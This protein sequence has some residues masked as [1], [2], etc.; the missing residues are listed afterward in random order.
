MNVALYIGRRLSFKP[1]DKR[2]KVPGVTIG[3]TGIALSLIVMMLS[4]SIVTGFKHEIRAKVMGFD[5][6]LNV[7]VQEGYNEGELNTIHLTDS[8]MKIVRGVVGER[9]RVTPMVRQPGILK[10]DSAFQGIVI[11]GVAPDYDWSFI[12]NAI[13]E[14]AVPHYAPGADSLDNTIIIS[15]LTARQLGVKAGDKLNAHF[16]RDNAIA[17]RRL[18]VAA[19][20]DT[21]FSDYDRMYAFTPLRMLQKLNH[22]DSLECG[23]LEINGVRPDRI[24]DYSDRLRVD[25]M[26]FAIETSPGRIYAVENVHQTGAVYFNWLSLLD[27]NVVVILI[28]MT[29]V[30]GFT[31]ISSLFILILDRVNTIGILKALGATNATIRS[32]FITMAERLVA[33]GLLTGNLI[34]L[35]LLLLQHYLRIIPLDPEAYYLSYVPVDIDWVD[36]I[37][38]NVG[39][40]V[41]SWLM[42]ILPSH[43]ISTLSPSQSIRYE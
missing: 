7:Y 26:E 42:L 10:T 1:G 15:S 13:V 20:F 11:K 14:G 24:D 25:L 18:R 5:S 8:L 30:A 41:V 43:M 16:I 40:A 36:I 34:G 38:L 22:L 28:L 4:I 12:H 39:V 19:V 9:A 27:T 6:Q 23:A 21:H 29:L 32:I 35:S 2:R 37:A 33:R 31:L 17:S 3:V